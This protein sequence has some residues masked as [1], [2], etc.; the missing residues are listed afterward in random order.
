MAFAYYIFMKGCKIHEKI[1]LVDY[2]K[3]DSQYSNWTEGNVQH[4]DRS[5][6]GFQH[7]MKQN[8]YQWEISKS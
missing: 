2:I 5:L 8:E 7:K 3:S 1:V 6:D 4:K